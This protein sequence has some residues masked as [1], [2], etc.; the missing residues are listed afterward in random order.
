MTFG[1]NPGIWADAVRKALNPNDERAARAHDTGA[2]QAVLDKA[3]LREVELAGVYDLT[4][5][6]HGTAQTSRP[7]RLRSAIAKILGRSA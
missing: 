7:S 6:V 1:P 5:H 4:P 3:E 2:E